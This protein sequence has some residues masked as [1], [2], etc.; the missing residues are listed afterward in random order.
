M[1]YADKMARAAELRELGAE[2][3]TYDRIAREIGVHE[4]TVSRWLSP[5][6]RAIENAK[7][8]PCGERMRA[9]LDADEQT[10]MDHI[11]A[12]FNGIQELGLNTNTG[13]L[14]QATHVLQGFV[15]QHMLERVAPEEWGRRW[16]PPH[17][18]PGQIPN[19]EDE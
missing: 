5:K 13:E 19:E 1:T 7:R 11:V 10:V 12:A 4:S 16:F 14:A 15:I 9:V 6:C 3:W 18:T 2:L 17:P 8:C